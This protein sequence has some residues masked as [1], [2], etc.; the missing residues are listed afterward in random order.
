MGYK[1]AINSQ[2]NSQVSI[3]QPR[4]RQM[5]RCMAVRVALT[6]YLSYSVVLTASGL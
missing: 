3:P 4:T 5:T 2:L 6:D 1:C